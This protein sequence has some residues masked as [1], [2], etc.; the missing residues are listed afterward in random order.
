[1]TLYGLS[2]FELTTVEHIRYLKT[3]V[4]CSR[5]T[6]KR[7]DNLPIHSKADLAINGR[8][9]LNFYTKSRANGLVKH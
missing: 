6:L 1:M 9:I 7:H 3:G 8:D 4:D 5:Q 2:P